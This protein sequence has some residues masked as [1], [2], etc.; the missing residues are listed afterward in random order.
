MHT[1]ILQ[2]IQETK[3]HKARLVRELKTA[4]KQ[5]RPTGIIDALETQIQ[6]DT[7]KIQTLRSL[8]H[9][10]PCKPLKLYV[11]ENVFTDYHPGIA[12]ALATN[13]QEARKLIADALN[14]NHAYNSFSKARYT[15]QA[16]EE[17]KGKPKIISSP[18][19]FQLAGGGG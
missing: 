14:K 4:K 12:F 11:W 7:T 15:Q 3:N 8:L 9:K 1:L 17:L 6:K 16:L 10:Q 18:K 19:G 2:E 5:W 13:V